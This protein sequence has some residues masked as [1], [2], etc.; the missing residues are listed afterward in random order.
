MSFSE[1][2]PTNWTATSDCIRDGDGD[3]DDVLS[4]LSDFD[5]E[6]MHWVLDAIQE[7]VALGG[8]SAAN[9]R[10]RTPNLTSEEKQARMSWLLEKISE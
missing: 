7:Y 6:F 4:N 1:I 2:D 3:G 10:L 8:T 9:E 5:G